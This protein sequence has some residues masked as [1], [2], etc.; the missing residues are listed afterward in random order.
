MNRLR[1]IPALQVTWSP[2]F[3]TT[4]V[5][6]MARRFVDE[7]GSNK[8]LASTIRGYERKTW[9]LRDEAQLMAECI[10]RGLDTAGFTAL[11][12][13]KQTARKDKWRLSVAYAA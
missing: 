8:I 1:S 2:D 12:L 6:D 11:A 13:V 7:D 4:L 3:V 9:K 10:A 5:A